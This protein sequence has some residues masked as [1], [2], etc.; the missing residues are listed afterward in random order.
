AP[1]PLASD[2]VAAG[3]SNTIQCQNPLPVGA[4]G[5]YMVRTKLSVPG[6]APLH[7]RLGETFCP[8][9]PNALSTC[10]LPIVPPD[11]TSALVSVKPTRVGVSGCVVVPGVPRPYV[12]SNV[13]VPSVE[14][15][16]A[17]VTSA[18]GAPAVRSRRSTLSADSLKM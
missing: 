1:A 17:N 16:A 6:G 11:A 14:P 9:Q 15:S 13:A 8:E 4:S 5:S 7:A 12:A 18:P 2:V 3:M 10:S